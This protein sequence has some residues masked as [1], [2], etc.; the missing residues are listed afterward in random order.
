MRELGIALIGAGRMGAFHVETLERIPE[1]TL[2]AIADPNEALA[3]ERIARRPIAWE[4][5]YRDVLTR[6]DVDAVCICSPSQLH[7]EMVLAAIDAGRH[8]FVEKPIATTLADGLRMAAA[9]EEAQLKLM[10]GHIERF[11]P[12]VSKLA[13][14]IAGGHLGR[15]FS[16]QATRVG[17]LPTRILDSGVTIDLATHDLDIMEFVLGRTITSL[18]ADARRF[19][20]PCHEDLISCLLRFG[21]DGP[22]GVLNVNWLTP[23]K[24]RELSVVGERGML[25]AAY[26]T[27]DL[28]FTESVDTPESWHDLARMRGA[29]E[30]VAMRFALRREEPLLA[31]LQ[32]FAR[33]VIDDT[34]EPVTAHD[35]CRALAAALAVLESAASSRAVSL[36]AVDWPTDST[37]V[38]AASP[39]PVPGS[40]PGTWD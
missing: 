35:G 5:D 40:E 30:G 17:P 18:Y 32:A 22:V 13:E 33:C 10:V 39:D 1:T 6:P 2:V 24:R 25:S 7:T 9:A 16:I 28:W 8:V 19:L 27:Q 37:V 34:P 36:E 14:L 21:E 4:A 3:R 12:A 26:L 31:E 29:T 15:V 20:H 23:R 11:N 38:L